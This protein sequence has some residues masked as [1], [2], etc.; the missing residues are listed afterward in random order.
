MMLTT[1]L[2]IVSLVV[3]IIAGIL[4]LRLLRSRDRLT[5]EHSRLLTERAAELEAFAGRV[6]HDLKNPL[7][8]M[9]VLVLLAG[10]HRGDETKLQEA[11]DRLSGQ[12]QRMDQTIDGL[13]E[14]AR[15]GANPAPGTSADLRHILDGIVS[16]VR[17][18]AEAAGTELRIAPFPPTQL[19]CGPAALTSV[20]SN[21]LGNAIKYIGNG[22]QAPRRITIRVRPRDEMTRIEVQ[23]TGPGLPPGAERIIF[24]PFRRLAESDQPGIGLGLATVKK[25]VEAYRGSVGVVSNRG[26]GSTFWFEMPNAPAESL[27]ASPIMTCEAA[28][29]ARTG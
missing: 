28:S 5:R 11:F 2:G 9:A 4:V 13:L 20:L 3:A 23:D 12:V 21:L 24:E 14:F 25:I 26:C 1:V 17:F 27:L 19:A 10:R 22:T 8:T 6:A 15:A 29:P 16:E 18:A 7:G